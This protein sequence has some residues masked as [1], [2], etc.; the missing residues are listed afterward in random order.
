MAWGNNNNSQSTVP[1][2][3]S[4]VVAISAGGSHSLALPQSPLVGM[5]PSKTVTSTSSTSPLREIY[6]FPALLFQGRNSMAL[7]E[8]LITM[9]PS[10]SPIPVSR[11]TLQA[12]AAASQAITAPSI[13]PIQLYPAILQITPAASPTMAAHSISPIR[14]YPAILQPTAPGVA[15]P[16]I[17]AHSLFPIPPSPAILRPR[18]LAVASTTIPAPSILQTPS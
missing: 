4:N 8:P 7:A 17:T 16:T 13:S 2:G 12:L 1:A 11:A 3:L 9:A 5:M 10:I 18:T 15:S 14:L 6:Q